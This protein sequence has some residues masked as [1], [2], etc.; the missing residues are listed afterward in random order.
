MIIWG[1]LSIIIGGILY[2]NG[3]NINND[4]DAQ[5]ESIFNDGIANPG[6]TY[7]TFGIILLF[8][9]FALLIMGVV[10]SAHKK[11]EEPTTENKPLETKESIPK[12]QEQS[13][14]CNKCGAVIVPDSKFC[15]ECGEPLVKK[16]E[17]TL[18]T[19]S[20]CR[21][22]IPAESKYCIHCGK[23]ISNCL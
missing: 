20:Y 2:A 17:D 7:E 13:S 21:E 23:A 11:D 14:T 8:A 19:C 6:A 16:Q 22:L 15:M 1:I 18:I 5:M 12:T 9:G 3:N 10:I 4:L